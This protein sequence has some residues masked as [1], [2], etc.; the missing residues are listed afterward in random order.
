[1][2]VQV[3]HRCGD[4]LLVRSGQH[5]FRDRIREG[6]DQGDTLGG[7]EGQVEPVHTRGGERPTLLTVGCDAVVQPGRGHSGVPRTA[8]KR[9]LVQPAQ[10]GNG[11]LVAG[12]Q[13][14][15]DP[16]VGLGIVFAQTT[17]GGL[18]V[19][20]R[21]LGGGGGVVVVAD[22]PPRQPRNR[23][24][25]GLSRVSG[26]PVGMTAPV[27]VWAALPEGDHPQYCTL[28][29]CAER[30]FGVGRWRAD[31]RNVKGWSRFRRSK[32]RTGACG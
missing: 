16:G 27:D 4:G 9:R 18:T 23:Q 25:L 29:Q 17:I 28:C 11:R 8:G 6:P 30:F 32:R 3:G 7:G 1:M 24:H 31:I 13:P 5:L 21:L 14:G 20:P 12:D 2:F 15:R 10:S 19:Q 22:A 26:S